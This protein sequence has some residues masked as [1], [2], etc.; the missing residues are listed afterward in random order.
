MRRCAAAS[1]T[2][3]ERAGYRAFTTDD[4]IDADQ[5]L[6]QDAYD[7]VVLDLG[8]PGMDGLAVL[9]RMRERGQATP[10]L[11]LSARDQNGRSRA[12]PRSR[13]R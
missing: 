3:L 2:V 12:R 7:L 10:A 9:R 8:L 4:G 6:K 11:I 13:R 1:K 5:M